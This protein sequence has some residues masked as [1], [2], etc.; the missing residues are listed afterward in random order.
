MQTGTNTC[1]ITL[2]HINMESLEFF[3]GFFFGFSLIG[4]FVIVVVF[5]KVVIKKDK[6]ILSHYEE[7]RSYNLT[8]PE[9]KDAV[10]E[11]LHDINATSITYDSKYSEFRAK[12]GFSIW[13][14]SEILTI[15]LQPSDNETALLFKSKCTFPQIIDWGKNHRNSKVF[16]KHLEERTKD[17]CSNI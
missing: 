16:F 11:V 4:I 1:I 7:S 17:K 3:N 9:F 13:S 2:T 8:M 6:F 5:W 14:W 12:T 15:K 10:D